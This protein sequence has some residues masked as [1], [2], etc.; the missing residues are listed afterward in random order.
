MVIRL[1]LSFLSGG[2]PERGWVR[3]VRC[4]DSGVFGSG[5]EPSVYIDRLQMGSVASLVLEITFS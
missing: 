5:P 4:G 2:A 1:W 3:S